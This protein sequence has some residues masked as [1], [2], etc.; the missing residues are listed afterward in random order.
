MLLAIEMTGEICGVAIGADA[1]NSPLVKEQAARHGQSNVI[2]PL[3]EAVLTEVN[4]TYA[5]ICALAV[6]TGP[7]SF[8]GLRAGLAT[9][10]GL[11]LSLRLPV[12][13]FTTHEVLAAGIEGDVLSVVDSRRAE[14]FYQLTGS[15]P[16]VGSIDAIKAVIENHPGPLTIRGVHVDHLRDGMND[17]PYT[18]QLVRPSALSLWQLAAIAMQSGQVPDGLPQPLYGRDPDVGQPKVKLY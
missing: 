13:G 11:G 6:S 8:T 15:A 9:V 3:I 2:M 17:G 7:G 12:Y 18:W 14:P 4:A 16:Q 1:D 10:Y 5:D